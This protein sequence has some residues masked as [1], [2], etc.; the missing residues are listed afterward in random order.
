M[1]LFVYGSLLRGMS[2]SSYMEGTKFI[3]PAYVKADMFYLGFYPGIIPG[4]QLV[5][6]ELYEVS[7]IQLPKIDEVEDYIELDNERSAYLRRP[8]EAIQLS[9]GKVIKASAYY[10]NRSPIDKPRIKCG[11]YRR[12]MMALENTKTWIVGYGSLMSSK[13]IFSK[14]GKI[15]EHKPCHIVGFERVYNVRSG[16]NGNAYA[17]IQYIDEKYRCSA[18]AWYLDEE[19][20][21]IIDAHENVPE[22]YLRVSVPFLTSEG[23]LLHGQTYFANS[24]AIS[25]NLHP[26]PNYLSMVKLGMLEHGLF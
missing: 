25:K 17:N 2:L 7:E 6:G 21:A 13:K 18:V 24:K 23:E 12:F 3:G 22:R 11:D 26:D 1:Q 8:I 14:L 10:Y 19:Q 20:I 4:N 16:L 9:D 5:Y 15:P